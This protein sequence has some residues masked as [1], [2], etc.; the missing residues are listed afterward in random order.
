MEIVEYIMIIVVSLFVLY[1]LFSLI[2]RIKKAGK[3]NCAFRIIPSKI[4]FRGIVI[5]LVTSGAFVYMS[6]GNKGWLSF[7]CLS[8]FLIVDFIDESIEIKSKK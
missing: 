6:R 1:A 5:L 7:L 8:I 4:I 2:L 3:A